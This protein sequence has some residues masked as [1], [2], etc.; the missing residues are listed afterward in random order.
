MRIAYD[1]DSGVASL[2]LPQAEHI[3]SG[4]YRCEARN[5]LGRVKTDC[6]LSVN[7]KTSIAYF[8]DAHYPTEVLFFAQDA[9]KI[10]TLMRSL[11]LLIEPPVSNYMSESLLTK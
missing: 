3:D 10:S 6:K 7:G 9:H 11:I 1:E 5:R 2:T 4:K 8:E